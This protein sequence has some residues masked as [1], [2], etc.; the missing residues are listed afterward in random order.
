M[1]Q[2][3]WPT[4]W[5]PE[6]SVPEALRVSI[7]QYANDLLRFNRSQNLVSRRDPLRQVQQLIW[8]GLCAA[9]A[10]GPSSG[11]SMD[12]GTGAGLPGVVLALSQRQS[13]MDLL[14][15]RGG[16]CEFLRREQKALDLSN[17][18]VLEADAWDFASDPG[19]T[20]K[21]SRV[22]L[23]AVAAPEKALELARPFLA[24][25]GQAL[26]LRQSKWQPNKDL[27][28]TWESVTQIELPPEPSGTGPEP[29]S[30]HIFHS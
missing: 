15:R 5:S 18:R 21:Y 29:T 30:I 6:L 10:V 7:T 20:G 4:S 26:L 2:F 25:D 23:K 19:N 1:N 12:L 14:E 27:A 9:K 24:S 16:R 13:K 11:D 8:E 22:W 28:K 3:A 17:V